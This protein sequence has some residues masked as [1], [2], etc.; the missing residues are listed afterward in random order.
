MDVIPESLSVVE[1]KVADVHA[2]LGYQFE[3]GILLGQWNICRVGK[4]ADM[5]V[6]CFQFQEADRVLWNSAKD[7]LVQIR[8]A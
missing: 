6:S 1:G 5:D 2:R 7:D 4:L 8:T 3:I